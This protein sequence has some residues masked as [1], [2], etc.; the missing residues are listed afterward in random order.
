MAP[1]RREPAMPGSVGRCLILWVTGPSGIEA[2]FENCVC[3]QTPGKQG[4]GTNAHVV[5]R[6]HTSPPVLATRVRLPACA[7]FMPEVGGVTIAAR[8]VALLKLTLARLEPATFGSEDQ[9]L[10]H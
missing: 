10:T 9:R 2:I 7:N 1:A 4:V 8:F 6:Y 3:F 5:W